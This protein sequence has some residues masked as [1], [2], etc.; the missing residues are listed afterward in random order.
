[1]HP[2]RLLALTLT[3]CCV[4]GC[5]SEPSPTVTPDPALQFQPLPPG[6]AGFPGPGTP[7][8]LVASESQ[9]GG[10]TLGQTRVIALGHCGLGSPLDFDGSLWDPL[11]GHDGQ[12]GPITKQQVSDLIN[13]TPIA[14]VLIHPDQAIA[15][16]EHGAS[17]LLQR[18]AGP[19]RYALCD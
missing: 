5:A 19:R 17:I 8:A 9:P 3:L 1:M 10:W 4:A 14:V 11:G 12:G 18:H 2:L 7:T 16:S 15:T 6:I 13:A